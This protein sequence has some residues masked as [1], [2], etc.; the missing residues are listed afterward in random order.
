M[1][2]VDRY[3]A[4]RHLQDVCDFNVMITVKDTTHLSNVLVRYMYVYVGPSFDART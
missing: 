3:R 1:D 4:R 2:I